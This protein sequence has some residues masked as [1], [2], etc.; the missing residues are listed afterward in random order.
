MP[1]GDVDEALRL[2]QAL[3]AIL[4]GSRHMYDNDPNYYKGASWPAVETQ[5]KE[6]S[7]A[8]RRIAEET[9]EAIADEFVRPSGS[10]EWPHTT[11]MDAVDKLIGALQSQAKVEA[12]LGPKGPQL[13]ASQ[14]HPW[15]WNA[16]VDLWHDGHYRQAVIA[17]SSAIFDS[18]LP[19]KLGPAKSNVGK[20]QVGKAFATA[21]PTPDNP[22]LRFPGSIEG[23]DEWT[24]MHE[25]AAALGRACAMGIRNV[26]THGAD[27]D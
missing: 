12:I 26:T 19:A 8:I 2:T 10:Y 17:A 20:D 4:I 16:A 3:R 23:T 9:D 22:R 13:V 7:W 14:L 6:A 5:I 11:M 24:N 27:P 1:V 18:H 21:K 25:G 15:V